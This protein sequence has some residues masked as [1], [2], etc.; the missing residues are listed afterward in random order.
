MYF[1][2]VINGIN[3]VQNNFTPEDDVQLYYSMSIA[4]I[5]VAE[6]PSHIST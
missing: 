4:I 1:I 3:R 2:I 6:Q 5:I